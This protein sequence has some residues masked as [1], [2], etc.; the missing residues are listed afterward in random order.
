MILKKIRMK[1]SYSIWQSTEQQA[2][3]TGNIISRVLPS[4][5]PQLPSTLILTFRV[6]LSSDLCPWPYCFANKWLHE[7][8]YGIKG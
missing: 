7:S 5:F 4:R 8:V 2:I 6:P 1:I 3:Y